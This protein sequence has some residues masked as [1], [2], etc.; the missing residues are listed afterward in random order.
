MDFWRFKPIDT[1]SLIEMAGVFNYTLVFLSA[2]VA[3]LAAYSSLIVLERIWASSNKKTLNL[4][5]WF[6]S[7]VLGVGVWA[8]HF[9]GM[10]AF[11]V[12]VSM[13]FD[14]LI[15]LISVIPPIFGA[16]AALSILAKRLFG[17]WWV[18]IGSLALASGIGTMHFV[19]MEAMVMQAEM[20]YDFFLF[21]GSIV[22]AHVL[23]TIALYVRVLVKTTENS[24]ANW[25]M[26]SAV[27]MGCAIA[28]MHY[29]AMASASYF[30][31]PGSVAGH[32][33]MSSNSVVLVLAIMAVVAIFVGVT[34][35]GVILD[36]RLQSAEDTA[37]ES[38]IRERAIVETLADGLMVIDNN[39]NIET[40]NM[41]AALIFGC[42]QESMIGK[43]I[44]LLMPSMNYQRLINDTEKEKKQIIGKT[45]ELEGSKVGGEDIP[46]EVTFSEMKI[47][48]HTMF[49][50]VMR[51]V[52][53]RKHLEEQLRHSQ[54]LE[55][56]GQ[57]AAGIAH[58]INTPVQYVSD[59][60]SF[61]K[62][63]FPGIFEV[64]ERCREIVDQPDGE[65]NKD[66]LESLRSALKKAKVDFIA[67]EIPK[68]LNQSLDGLDRI[69]TIVSAMKSFS[70][71]SNGEKNDID[72]TEAIEATV[73]VARSEWKYVAEVKYEFEE[74]LPP[75][76]CLRDEFNQVVLNIVIN[77][78][79]AIEEALKSSGRDMGVITIAA[80]RDEQFVEVVITD[81]GQG[82]PKN[83]QRKIFDPF[84][85]TKEVG[86]GTG[87]GLSIAYN[88]IVEKHGGSISVDSK[89]GMGTTFFIRL[90]LANKLNDKKASAA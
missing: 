68:A 39:G 24:R 63:G 90:P 47:G 22:V 3:A 33:V 18:Q 26:A 78:A 20:A 2:C 4:W 29:T 73:T 82:M 50:V 58:E 14:P 12:P 87:Q 16:Y 10:L 54:K 71:A 7:I 69:A 89:E 84:F 51:D 32:V 83:I 38:E 67:A 46:L 17:F 60:T 53:E 43:K 6:G 28:G 66:D 76:P 13:T 52:T 72:I 62:K 21:V 8:M 34:V 27:V 41:A 30:I 79:H 42:A 56:M 59:N 88:V 80:K 57:L 55:S 49:N 74:N 75:V 37:V 77:A 70:H 9:T 11:M 23:A 1:E 15:T 85:T 44:K 40:F 31:V 64:L 25:R 48:A 86:K 35:I 5:L 19:G 81:D 45:I 61:M 36:R 65:I